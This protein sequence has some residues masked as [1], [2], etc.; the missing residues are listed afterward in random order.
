MVKQIESYDDIPSNKLVLIDFFAPWCG[1]C[2]RIAPSFSALEK[3]FP[4]VTFLKVDVDEAEDLATEFTI[5][6]LPTFVFMK[7]KKIIHKVEG[8]DLKNVINIL[9]K[10][11]E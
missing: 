5:S 11:T 10:L 7:D 2:Q 6:S 4:T 3:E 8:A 9:T 1:P